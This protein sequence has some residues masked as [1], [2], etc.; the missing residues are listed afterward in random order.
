MVRV[1]GTL[2]VTGASGFLGTQIVRRILAQT[3]FRVLALV[4]GEDDESAARR[5]SRAWWDWPELGRAIG[6]Q[7]HVVRGDVTQPRL[8]L[9]DPAYEQLAQRVTHIVHSAADLRLRGPLEELRQTNVVGTREILALARAVHADHGLT[10]LSHVSTAYV[11]ARTQTVVRE[12]D[13]DEGAGAAPP[14]ERSK[15]EG[16]RLVR[17]V[18]SEF[19]TTVLRPGMIV[20]DSRS[21]E[22]R[23]FNTVYAPLRLY[24]MGRLRV[25]PASPSIRVNLVPVDYV[26]QAAVALS[27]DE[28]AAGL[29]FHLTAP[30]ESLPTFHELAASARLWARQSL[31]VR[32]APL[33]FLPIPL[34]RAL[35]RGTSRGVVGLLQTLAPYLDDRRRF[36]RENSD[37][38]L[39]TYE[40][41]WREFLPRLLEY[42][43]AC[44]FLHRS[45]RTVHEQVLSRLAGRSRRVTYHDVAGGEAHTRSAGDVRQDVLRAAASLR[46][47]GVRKGDRVAFVGLNSTRWLT[48]DVAIG[49]LGAVS[50][51]LYYTSPPA[52]IDGILKDSK[53]RILLVGA[54]AVLARLDEVTTEIPIVSF[55]RLA[56]AQSPRRRIIAWEEFL[57]K[58]A[59]EALAPHAPVRFDDLAT[60][61]YTSGTTG[62]P[63]GVPFHHGNL[64]FMAESLAS[65]VPWKA[66]A[67]RIGMLSFLP[68]NHVVEG[69]LAT[70]APYYAPAPLDLSFLEDFRALA[71]ALPRVRPTFFFSV[72]RFY[73]KVWD[74]VL[75][76]PILRGMAAASFRGGPFARHVAGRV[77]LRRAGLDRCVQLL[78]GSAPAR[79]DVLQGLGRL[80]IDVHNAYGL[81]EAPLVTLN[82]SGRNRLGTVGEPLPKTEVR[83]AADGEIL[84]RGPQVTPERL[85]G[86]TELGVRD[87]WLATGDL[88][89]LDEV[90]HLIISGRKKE[91]IVTAYGKNVSPEKVEALLR[92]VPGVR[93]ALLVGDGEAYCVSLLWLEDSKLNVEGVRSIDRAVEALNANLSHPERVKAW[94][95]LPYNLSI[96]GGELTANL[97]LR[98]REVVARRTAIV[99]ALYGRAPAP[100]EARSIGR[101]KKDA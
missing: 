34:H 21:G 1:S 6:E 60:L 17:E 76:T 79:D 35:P 68:M 45:D 81:T 52:E 71:T 93:E 39:G 27:L 33:L 95:L 88:G 56:P 37:R 96:D 85:G 86:D 82:R 63:K 22:I 66:R 94:A 55:C 87:G 62:R 50:V 70:Y 2:L 15:R 18:R 3:D 83:L 51:P 78:V 25:V 10:R 90:G 54:P 49:L 75:E 61:R 84:V 42:A 40:L 44:G 8:G 30:S 77:V 26:A 97:K 48:L 23:T 11:A 99:D 32:L 4:R 69:L 67:R 73:E 7:V 29:T 92:S 46:A 41:D 43:V 64:R 101:A 13:L 31:G 72:P 16:E 98:R 9:S 24:L 38:L 100:A 36:L 12:Q 53:A 91:L 58:G 14:Y 28:R 20:G 59:G 80:G 19:P 5:L 89:Q 47:M 65:L 57:A 74:Q